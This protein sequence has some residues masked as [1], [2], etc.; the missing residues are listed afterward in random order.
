MKDFSGHNIRK[1]KER[2]QKIFKG[3]PLNIQLKID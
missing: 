2:T 1:G 3:N